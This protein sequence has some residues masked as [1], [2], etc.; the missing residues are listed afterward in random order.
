MLEH[1]Y[2]VEI[3]RN[4]IDTVSFTLRGAYLRHS[5][6][7]A[8][9]TEEAIAELMEMDVRSALFLSPASLVT[10]MQ[11]SGIGDA[12]AGYV[13][14]ALNKLGDSYCHMKNPEL[15]KI[16]YDQARAVGVAFNWRPSDVPQGLERLD[17]DLKPVE[18]E[19]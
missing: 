14:Y 12:T 7:E 15:A 2:I 13:C 11:L 18:D 10:M 16:R 8:K 6:S 19:V 1:D 5:V 9:Q 3:V 17:S 4:F